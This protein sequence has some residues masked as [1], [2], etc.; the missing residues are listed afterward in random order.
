MQG[1]EVDNAEEHFHT[2]SLK[3][4]IDILQKAM[5]VAIAEDPVFTRS[6]HFKH[7]C[8][9]AIEIYDDLYKDHV[10]RMKQKRITD[11]FSQ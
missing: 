10:R 9:A 2:H 11:F 1:D 8:T 4:I 5:D 6:L 7:N 3:K